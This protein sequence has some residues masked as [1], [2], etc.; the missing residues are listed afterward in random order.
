M[1]SR[2]NRVPITSNINVDL[3]NILIDLLNII[4]TF[5]YDQILQ[6]KNYLEETQPFSWYACQ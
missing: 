4:R 5:F 2:L 3:L 6:V 1:E